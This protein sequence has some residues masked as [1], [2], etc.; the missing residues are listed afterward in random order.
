MATPTNTT[1]R[2]HEQDQKRTISDLAREVGH[3]LDTFNNTSSRTIL[4]SELQDRLHANKDDLRRAIARALA[5]RSH[6]INCGSLL[7]V[8]RRLKGATSA[9]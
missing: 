5:T 6:W 4:I 8:S 3:R 9:S 7:V 2:R 1:P